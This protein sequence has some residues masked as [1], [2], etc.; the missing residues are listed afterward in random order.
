MKFCSECGGPLERRT[1]SHDESPRLVCTRCRRIH[2]ENPKVLVM[3]LVTFESRIL[4]ARRATEPR[5]GFWSPPAGF[6]EIGESL[7]EAAARE[8]REETG[9]LLLP[10]ELDLHVVSNLPQIGEVYVC[11]RGRAS[12]DQATTSFECDRCRFFAHDEIPWAELAYPDLTPYIAGLFV[13][14]SRATHSIHY[15]CTSTSGTRV[16][17]YVIGKRRSRT[18]GSAFAA[19]DKVEYFEMDDDAPHPSTPGAETNRG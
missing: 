4:L 3:S 19:F 6:V 16:T 10:G 15:T 12:S 17:S 14:D 5:A 9:V 7:E 13:E 8:I 18:E 2:F 1:V 11:F